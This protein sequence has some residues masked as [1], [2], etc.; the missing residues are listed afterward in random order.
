MAGTLGTNLL[1]HLL[2][3]SLA[4]VSKKVALY[5]QAW[6]DAGHAGRGH[7]TLMLHTFVGESLESVKA[8]V[9]EPLIE[10]LRTSADLIKGYG[11]AFSAFK[12]NSDGGRGLDFRTLPKEEMD[13]ILE[14]AF[15]R[16]FETSGL[17]GT[18]ESCS[19]IIEVL[20]RNDIDEVACLIDFGVSPA[21]VL[22]NLKYLDALRESVSGSSEGEEE[23]YSIAS[24]IQR[25][26]VTH[27][28][29]TPSMAGMLLLDERNQ[30]AFRGLR[31]LLIGG[32]AFPA[33]LAKQ[34]RR[35]V[36]GEIMNMYGPT[37]TTIWSST[38]QVPSEPARVPIGRPIANTEIYILDHNLLPVPVGIPGE[39]LIGGEGVARG[40]LGRT[41]LTAERFIHNPFRGNGSAR[42]Y[43]TGDLARYLPD[44]NLEILGRMD[45]QVKIR[46]HRVELGEIE[47]VLNEH[48]AV[49]ECVVIAKQASTGDLR[50]VAYVVPQNAEA[51]TRHE[52][53]QYAREK[54][55][56]HMV[57]AELVFMTAFPHTPNQKIDRNALPAPNGN[58]GAEEEEFEPPATPV[59]EAVA[60]LWG[61]LLGVQRISRRDD[62]FESGGHSLLAMQFVS[63]VRDRFGVELPLKSLFERPTVAGLAEAIDALVWAD[64]A[65][66]PAQV[67][68][69]R[70]EV[71]L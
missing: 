26:D 8:T 50:L 34:L 33:T 37:E 20:K 10:Y 49:R 53:R 71:V 11:W 24:L 54:L 5:R 30:R 25:H 63:R 28:Q 3:Q 64:A 17:F 43:R 6:N 44:G 2:G 19:K 32:E 4:E 58:S 40:Y 21:V 60:A 47:A 12:H 31:C 65:K 39:L 46:G 70:E 61:E 45:H 29:C 69:N 42:L 48:P 68:E 41:E 15:N 59:E 56:E 55:P 36:R 57:P 27:L 35:I 23:D 9:R 14:H 13:A 16:Y 67:L 38:Y 51:P 66:S 62:F 7:V 18:P 1:T 52:L 22:N